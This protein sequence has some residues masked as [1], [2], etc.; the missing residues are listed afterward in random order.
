MTHTSTTGRE[1]TLTFL[2]RFDS[3]PF[4]DSVSVGLATR[5]ATHGLHV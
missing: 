2:A 3:L 4:H 5:W 1:D